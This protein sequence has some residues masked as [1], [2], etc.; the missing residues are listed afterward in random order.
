MNILTGIYETHIEV[1]DLTRAMEFY[2]ETLGLDR[3]Y[4]DDR[5][6]AFYFV[7]DDE[8]RSMLGLW[9]TDEVSPRHFAFR[10]SEERID[11]MAAF[12]AERDIP[13]IEAFDIAPE[14]QPLVQTWM[15][16]AAIYFEAPRRKFA[17][18][19][20]RPLRRAPPRTRSG[21]PRRVANDIRSQG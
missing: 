12:L 9:E 8:D 3:G 18:A 7:S 17:G 14:E 2:E 15:P 10:V 20:R 19:Y 6:I 4:I 13:V 5:H 21:A 11:D 1:S 16:A